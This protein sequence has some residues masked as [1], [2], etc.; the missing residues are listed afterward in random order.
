MKRLISLA[1]ALVIALIVMAGFVQPQSSVKADDDNVNG[2]PII[3]EVQSAP[4]LP[5]DVNCFYQLPNGDLVPVD[6][7]PDCKAIFYS[8]NE[9]FG[10]WTDTYYTFDCTAL[11]APE[12]PFSVQYWLQTA[13]LGDKME[14]SGII[15]E[16]EETTLAAYDYKSE[17]PVSLNVRRWELTDLTKI[18]STDVPR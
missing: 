11:V 3:C 4:G 18:E 15:W 6:K 14:Y 17:G 8:A 2:Y 13:K 10:G 16:V 9:P 5:D 12:I 1:A 7:T